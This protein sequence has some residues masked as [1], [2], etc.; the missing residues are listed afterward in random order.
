MRSRGRS[1]EG[2]GRSEDCQRNDETHT[3]KLHRS[4]RS[5][6]ELFQFMPDADLWESIYLDAAM[7]DKARS[8]EAGCNPTQQHFLMFDNEV[9]GL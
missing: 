8:D 5:I 3:S 7:S 2:G 1:G 4:V 6:P 9:K